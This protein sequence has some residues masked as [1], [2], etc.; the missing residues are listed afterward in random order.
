MALQIRRGLNSER[1]SSTV[2]QGEIVWTTDTKKL[3]VGG[4]SGDPHGTNVLK[5][6]AG[7]GLIWN[8]GTEQLDLDVGT[9][10]LTTSDISESTNKY[11]TPTR[12]KDAVGTMFQNATTTGITFTYDDTTHTI[13]ATVA[14]D[15]V[16]ITSV[17]ADTSPELGGNL[18]LNSNDITGIGNID[19]I[20]AISTQAGQDITASGNLVADNTIIATVGLGADLP[21]NTHSITGTG[22]IN[23]TGS[24]SA[25]QYGTIHATNIVLDQTLTQSGILIE[26]NTGGSSGIDLFNI[27][28]HH[29]DTDA[30]GAF[31]SRSRGSYASPLSLTTGDGIFNLGF[32]GRTSNGNIGVAAAIATFV[33]GAVATDVLPGKFAI[34]TSTA[35]GVLTEAFSIDKAQAATFNYQAKF[36]DGSVGAPSIAFSSDASVDTGFYHPGDGIIGVACNGQERARFDGGGIR[37]SGFI[38]VAQ[39]SGVL[40]NPPE[41]GMI[42]LDGTT[43]KG[44]NGGAWVDLN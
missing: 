16:G 41:A 3:Y 32:S 36:S 40:P 12:A 23:I 11:F 18:G 24:V 44:Y 21:L 9:L 35:T 42:V 43:F 34:Y 14:L 27:N 7:P 1:L 20:G 4:V 25:T 37:S 31:F 33:D 2:A 22:N 5:S 38:K 29:N 8:D 17:Q 30:S 19:I 13:T 15:G 10:Q 28:T 26:S 6:T 39:V